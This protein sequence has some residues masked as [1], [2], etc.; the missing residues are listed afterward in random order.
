MS[1]VPWNKSEGLLT[2]SPLGYRV[3]LN[4]LPSVSKEVIKKIRACLRMVG[5]QEVIWSLPVCP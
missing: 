4:L 3:R 5:K 1:S 2:R